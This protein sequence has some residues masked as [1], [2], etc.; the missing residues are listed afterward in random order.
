MSR[1]KEEATPIVLSE[2]MLIIT[3]SFLNS[4]LLVVMMS[5][6]LVDKVSTHGLLTF[7]LHWGSGVSTMTMMLK[8]TM[9]TITSNIRIEVRYGVCIKFPN[10]ILRSR[11][12]I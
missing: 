2:V 10:L 11:M 1:H 7:S 12:W 8:R 4:Y 3:V 6:N 9:W 5:L